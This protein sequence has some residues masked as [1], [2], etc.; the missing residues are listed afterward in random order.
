LEI[1][2]S[3][4]CTAATADRK[5]YSVGESGTIKAVLNL[6]G[7]EGAVVRTITVT[8]D[9]VRDNVYQLNLEAKIPDLLT[10]EP[11]FLVWRPAEITATKTITLYGA[12]YTKVE[13]TNATVTSDAFTIKSKTQEDKVQLRITPRAGTPAITA[14]LNADVQINGKIPVH[15]KVILRVLPTAAEMDPLRMKGR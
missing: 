13:L 14:E 3:C 7:L 9:E 11:Q 5:T 2:T 8:T 15:R 6:N 12:A 4:G 10:I 1:K